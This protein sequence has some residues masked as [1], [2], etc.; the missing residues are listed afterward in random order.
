MTKQ[1]RNINKVY[2]HVFL[3]ESYD[4]GLDPNVPI[5]KIGN[6]CKIAGANIAFPACEVS[7]D[8]NINL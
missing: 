1:E 3:E 4:L 5:I 7:Y 6:L 2:L 8:K